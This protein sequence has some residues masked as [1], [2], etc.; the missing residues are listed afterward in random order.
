MKFGGICL[1]LLTAASL[2]ACGPATRGDGDDIHGDDGDDDG[3]QPD[4]NNCVATATTELSCNDGFD[5]DCDGFLDCEDV[6]CIN[7]TEEGCPSNNC[8]E[9]THPEST[10]ARP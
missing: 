4:A 7:H 6:D 1:A 2:G 3:G 8:G 10:P 5:E 9:L